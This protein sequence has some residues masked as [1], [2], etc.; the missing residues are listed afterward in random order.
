[1]RMLGK[2][3][4]SILILLVL[5]NN[6]V[7]SAVVSDNDGSAF[8][9][10]AEYDSLKTNFQSVIDGYNTNIDAKIDDAIASY[11]AGITAETDA[12]ADLL[13]PVSSTTA[14]KP[15]CVPNGH[16]TIKEQTFQGGV[17]LHN[18]WASYGSGSPNTAAAFLPFKF[19]NMTQ[20][21]LLGKGYYDQ[22][23]GFVFSNEDPY[24]LTNKYG[25]DNCNLILSMTSTQNQNYGQGGKGERFF[26]GIAPGTFNDLRTFTTYTNSTGI[27]NGDLHWG[28]G[29]TMD[30]G[31][32]VDSDNVPANIAKNNWLD[33]LPMDDAFATS[34]S[35]RDYNS[36]YN[37]Q[38]WGCEYFITHATRNEDYNVYVYPR[39]TDVIYA[40]ASD[41]S[42][43][44]EYTDYMTDVSSSNV[45]GGVTTNLFLTNRTQ[46]WMWW[47][48]WSS[49]TSYVIGPRRNWRFAPKFKLKNTTTVTKLKPNTPSVSG[50]TKYWNTLDQFLNGHIK[51]KDHEG[52]VT[53]PHFYGGIPLLAVSEDYSKFTFDIKLSPTITSGVSNFCVRV[54]SEEFPNGNDL[55]GWTISQKSAL[56]KVKGTS[57]IESIT[58]NYDYDETNNYLVIPKNTNVTI[59]VDK[60]A[61]NKTYFIR[62]WEEGNAN[63]AGGQIELL[64]NGKVTKESK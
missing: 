34:Y 51:Y 28:C 64:G 26:M 45:I 29:T 46:R 32:F 13:F 1:M 8:I 14:N 60:P 6:M 41:E 17:Y 22:M 7:F 3:I 25:Y 49:D 21:A 20:L 53:S 59:T 58:T 44:E 23:K 39:C 52:A 47:R 30:Q 43:I 19:N 50:G 54:M 55:S 9:T 35:L 61:K 40:H 2:R 36:N 63:S 16:N 37:E 18:L 24:V 42:R 10:R 31:Y 5:L 11:L 56:Q 48:Q 15:I 33:V 57:K 4:W 62:W 27:G 38:V 12:P